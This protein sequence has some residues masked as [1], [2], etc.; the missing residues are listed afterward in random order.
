MMHLSNYLKECPPCEQMTFRQLATHTAGL[1]TD[2]HCGV[3][4]QNCN[5]TTKEQIAE[6]IAGGIPLYPPG[7]HVSQRELNTHKNPTALLH[8]LRSVNFV[9]L[10]TNMPR[11]SP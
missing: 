4:T 7:G 6:M 3:L 10:K 9:L 11:L 1:P 5:T 2:P 8:P